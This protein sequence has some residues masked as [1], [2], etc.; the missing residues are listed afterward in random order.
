[1]TRPAY[2]EL[3]ATSHFSFLRGASSC[4]ELF[5][6]A[7]LCGIE[8]VAVCDHNTVAGIVRAHEAAKVTGVRLIVGCRLDLTDGPGILV[9]PLDRS[10]YGRLC[11]LLSLGKT[12]GGKARCQIDWT[13]LA[14]YGEGLAAVLVAVEADD[15]CA[16]R[17]KRLK[18]TYGDQ[19]YLALS[20]RYRPGDAKRLHD[21]SNLAVAAGVQTLVTNNVLFHEPARQPLQDVM[22]CTRLRCTIDRLGL[23]RE[24]QDGNAL[25][26]PEEMHRLFRAYPEAL[27]RT[28]ALA[29]WLRFSLEELAYQYPDEVSEPG[30]T[31][32]R[33]LAELT[34]EGAKRRYPE[35]VTCCSSASSARS[36][37]SPRTSTSISSTSAGRS[38]CSGCS[39]PTAAITPRSVRPLCA[40][41]PAA[42]SATSVR[43]WACPRT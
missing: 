30:K 26:P 9:Y 8:A 7:A 15:L 14:H 41:E 4:E 39:T 27:A 33:T 19:A 12:R 20:R 38:S 1:M 35:G 16:L 2:A 3:Q 40:T 18:Q 28:V 36:A 13:D 42:P 24:S 29:D 10:G 31:P 43:R 11:R 37:R 17:L 25:K 34:W 23:R 21:L 6:Q 32:Q 5:S 22:A